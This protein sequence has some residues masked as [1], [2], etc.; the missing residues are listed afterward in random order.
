M[1]KSGLCDSNFTSGN[2]ELRSAQ[3]HSGHNEDSWASASAHADSGMEPVASEPRL[4][5]GQVRA[6]PPASLART[7]AAGGR[8]ERPV[9]SCSALALLGLAPQRPQ[10]T[11]R[12]AML[13]KAC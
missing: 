8:E 6:V 7:T 1:G 9:A 10:D 5:V 2:S 13:G 12:H 11:C 3:V 4:F